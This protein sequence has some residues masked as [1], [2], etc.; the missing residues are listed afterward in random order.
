MTALANISGSDVLRAKVSVPGELRTAEWAARDVWIRERAFFM[1]SVA[2]AETLQDFRD[3]VQGMADGTLS[4]GEA[5]AQIGEKLAASGYAPLPGQEGTI[6]DLRTVERKNV[7]LETNLAQ[8]NGWARWERQQQSLGGYPAQQFVRLRMS[9]VPRGDWPQ[10]FATAV[11]ET[12]P[13]GANIGAMAALTNHPC[14]SRLS[15]FGSPY[16]PFDFNSGMGL[17]VL[18]REEADALGLLPEEDADPEHQAMMEPQERGLNETLAATPA[19]RS[20]EVRTALAEDVK[21]L[22]KWEGDTL[23]FTDPNGTRPYTAEKLAEVITDLLP[24]KIPHLQAAAVKT[25]AEDPAYFRKYP[26]SDKAEDL[27]RFVQRTEP[28]A[29]GTPIYRGESF[30]NE[31]EFLARRA[32]ILEGT[33]LGKIAGS[34][35]LDP[36]VARDFAHRG[37]PIRVVY[38]IRDNGEARP[39][40]PTVARVSPQHDS[41]AEVLYTEANKFRLL[42]KTRKEM[43]DG[44]LYT[45]ELAPL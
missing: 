36:E 28:V 17:E 34:G 20:Q 27:L 1:A 29:A 7:A 26:G 22:A 5:R 15:V 18:D 32:Q 19:V 37:G 10:R 25:W 11:N 44:I 33:S 16:A 12:T 38:T 4:L 42:S 30:D 43:P 21:G 24:E 39:I 6:K 40:S 41:E 45:I 31:R 2:K 13:E 9:K 3:A 14:W 35:T 23:R 8:V